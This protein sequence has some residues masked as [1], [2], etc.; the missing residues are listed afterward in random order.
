[1]PEETL[2]TC[3]E[4][5]QEPFA[6]ECLRPLN[7][8]ALDPSG[9]SDGAAREDASSVQDEAEL[10][11]DLL[12]QN[13]ARNPA[14]IARLDAAFGRRVKRAAADRRGR[15]FVQRVQEVARTA[16]PPNAAVLVISKGDDALLDLGCRRA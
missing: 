14:R 6:F 11:S 9:T 8:L 3:L 5:V 13:T 4:F 2:R 10:F 7:G 12:L 16:L 15:T 1:D